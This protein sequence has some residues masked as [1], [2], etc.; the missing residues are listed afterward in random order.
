MSSRIRVVLPAP[1]APRT[2]KISGPVHGEGEA[3]EDVE[4]TVAELDLVRCEDRWHC[5]RP[6]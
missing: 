5:W 4:G 6:L 1:L 3:I 2:P